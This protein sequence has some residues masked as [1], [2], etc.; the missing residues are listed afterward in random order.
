MKQNIFLIGPMGV[1]KTTIGRQLAAT[2]KREFKDSDRE[3]EERTGASIPLI[4]ELEGE[5][6]FRKR[7]R[8]IIDELTR[9][10]A[11]VLATGG[12]VVLDPDNRDCLRRRGHVVYL[13]APIDELL[14]R[15]SQNRNRPLLQTADPRKR[16]EDI[17][18]QRNPLYRGMADC[19]VETGRASIR[20]VVKEILAYFRE[21]SLG[22]SA[23]FIEENLE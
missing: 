11:I 18:E 20:Q 14:R 7:E 22:K 15:T 21:K 17:L 13:H 5:A 6:G 16:L 2:L 9:L 3:I 1:G 8:E 19:V 23:Y 10:P 12:G 4:F